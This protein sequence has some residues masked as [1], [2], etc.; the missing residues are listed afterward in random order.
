MSGKEPASSS[1]SAPGEARVPELRLLYETAPIGL[2]FL[3]PDCRY[4]RINRRLCEICGISVDEHLGRTVRETIPQLAEQVETIVQ[5]IVRT[6][7]PITGIEISGQRRDGGNADRVWTT[8]WYPLIAPDG[9]IL[10][11]NVASE[12]I[13]E[14]KRMEAA[15]SASEARARELAERMRKLNGELEQRVVTEARERVRI[16]NAARQEISEIGRH[17][18]MSAMAA[19][20][21]HEVSQPLAAAVL[22]AEA[23][24]Q[25]L[26]ATTPDLDET[27]AVM[28]GIVDDA[29]RAR[30]VLDGIRSMFRNDGGARSAVTLNDLICEVL[31]VV[32]GELDAHQVSLRS[33]LGDGLPAVL[34]ARTQLQQVVLNLVVNAIEAM[35]SVTTR[36]RVLIVR[37]ETAGSAHV[38]ITVEDTGS[39]IDPSIAD[40]VFE[41]FFTTKA[42]GM[43]MGLSICRSI[44]ESHGGRLSVSARTPGGSSFCVLLPSASPVPA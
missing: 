4:Q 33:E 27:R 12:E 8:S 10:G 13:T 26:S 6:G 25:M 20:V 40:R 43:G 18:T 32:R 35:S 14:R 11:I 29:Q 17:M 15:L 21:A 9:S 30:M 5:Q 36:E 3:T 28:K 42:L 31:A 22:N 37:S 23:A 38:Q 19:S 1:A 7:Q 34:A 41:A 39:G 44:V 16:W 24:L 2:A